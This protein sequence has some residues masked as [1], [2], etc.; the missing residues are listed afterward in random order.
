MIRIFQ[1][2]VGEDELAALAEVFD[3]SWL[4]KGPRADAFEQ[5]FAGHLGVDAEQVT[6]ISSCTAGLFMAAKLADLGP[7]CEAVLPTV[8]YVAA[9]NAVAATGA[10]PVFCDVDERTLNPTV[11]DVEAAL[12]KRTRAVVLL[13]YGG[14]PGDVVEIARLCRERGVLLIEDSACSVA[15][16]VGEQACG[17][18]GDI[19]LWSFDSM[20]I[21]VTGD[22]GMLWARDPEMVARGRK[23]AYLGLEQFSGLS[24]APLVE[25]RWWEFEVSSFSGRSVMNDMQAAM[26]LVQLPKVEAFIKR[27]RAVAE[28]YD[29]ELVDLT[30]V[31]TPPPLPVDHRSSYYL[32]WVQMEPEVRDRVA[33]TLLERGIYTTFRY[34]ALHR[35]RAYGSA[36][37]LPRA[38]RAVDRTLCLPLHQ[39]LTDAD[40][41]R[42]A[43]EFRNAV[44]SASGNSR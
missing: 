24:Q 27:R 12:T 37:S 10:R 26:G 5:A 3:S 11:D 39:A 31:R 44:S 41:E 22:G 38:E 25:S 34:P 15:S 36:A 16:R 33:R 6:S 32:Y 21:L 4:G 14:Y 29:R 20:K 42:I 35:V 30:G 43:A 2:T 40:V 9:G 19:G 7:D 28:F 13:H 8:S 1:P 18:V 23:L 17:T